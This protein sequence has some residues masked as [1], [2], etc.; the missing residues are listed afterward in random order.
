M[1][2]DELPADGQRFEAYTHLKHKLN[3]QIYP[4]TPGLAKNKNMV[5]CDAHGR[6][7]VN[8]AD[9]TA[10]GWIAPATVP[11]ATPLTDDRR[12]L[13]SVSADAVPPVSAVVGEA[14][15]GLLDNVVHLVTPLPGPPYPDD[16]KARGWKFDVDIE[17]LKASGTWALAALE[18]RPWLLL[19]WCESWQSIPVGSYPDDDA[20]IAARIGMPPS[21]FQAWRP[22]LMRGWYKASDG[23]LYH[24]VITEFV[25]AMAKKRAKE[26]ARVERWRSNASVTRNQRVSTTPT[27][28]PTPT[29]TTTSPSPT[30]EGVSPAEAATSEQAKAIP[31]CPHEAIIAAY[32]E[33]LP[34]LPRVRVWTAARKTHLRARWR[35]RA[36]AG[37]YATLADGLAYWRGFFEHVKR[38]AFLTGRKPGRTGLFF[39]SLAWLVNAEKFAKVI[40][41]DYDDA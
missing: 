7:I 10:R 4:Y 29:P 28:T 24:G 14:E 25:L 19:L 18:Q 23:L 11:A 33:V 5:L 27:P 31:D 16:I 9:V 22:T 17:R 8:G 32:H 39:A 20:V 30:G 34:E 36:E 1:V 6:E 2:P 21:Q 37:E 13:E 15:P 12:D 41:G 35:E 40:E 38:S 26:R 3:G